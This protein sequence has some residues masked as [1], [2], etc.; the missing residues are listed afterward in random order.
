MKY[1]FKFQIYLYDHL[2][3][4]KK[5]KSRKESMIVEIDKA[6]LTHESGQ[7]FPL[8]LVCSGKPYHLSYII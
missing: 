1:D 6:Y 2:N 5:Y 8:E 3:F 7:I 4:Q